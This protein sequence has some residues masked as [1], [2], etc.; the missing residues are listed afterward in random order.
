MPDAILDS[1]P[2]FTPTRILKVAKPKAIVSSFTDQVR[3][4]SDFG[5]ASVEQVE[6]GITYLVNEFWTSGQRQ[7][8]SL[9]EISYRACFK[10]QLPEFL[11]E[12][13]T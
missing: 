9:H 3:S 13:L 8:H 7:S 5:Q 10:A 6:G 12:R 2:L 1:L 4:F 11:I